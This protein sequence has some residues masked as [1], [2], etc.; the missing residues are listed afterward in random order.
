MQACSL[1]FHVRQLNAMEV[2]LSD[3]SSVIKAPKGRCSSPTSLIMSRD[4]QTETT[5][6]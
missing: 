5:S 3:C 6:R 4:W 1:V 2:A